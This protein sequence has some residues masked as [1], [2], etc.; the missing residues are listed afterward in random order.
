MERLKQK[1]RDFMKSAVLI[2]FSFC[3]CLPGCA[4]NMEIG[5][6]EIG[7][8]KD[9]KSGSVVKAV[10]KLAEISKSSGVD[11]GSQ[12]QEEQIVMALK[13]QLS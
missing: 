9:E 7:V 2:A 13:I 8:N 5:G 10:I 11:H 6:D 3:Y 4:P 12:L 1:G